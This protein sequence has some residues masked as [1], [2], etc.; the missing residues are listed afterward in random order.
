MESDLSRNFRV[1]LV[2]ENLVLGSPRTSFMYMRVN[3]IAGCTPET[4]L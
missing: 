4:L 3:N 1:K 2:P